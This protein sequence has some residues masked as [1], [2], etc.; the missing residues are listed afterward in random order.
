MTSFREIV[1]RAVHCLEGSYALIIKSKHFPGEAIGNAPSINPIAARKG[2]P[3]MFGI[4]G[5]SSPESVTVHA[6]KV[7]KPEFQNVSELLKTIHEIVHPDDGVESEVVPMEYFLSS[8][9]SAIIEHTRQII[10]L[11]VTCL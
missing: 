4:R 10:F 3:L 2:S 8:D 1:S 6:K 9:M 7:D 5:A 11:E